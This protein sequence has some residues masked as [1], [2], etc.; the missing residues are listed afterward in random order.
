MVAATYG[1]VSAVGQNIALIPTL[2]TGM[3]WFPRTKGLAMGCVVGGF[4]GGSL[5][6]NYIITAIINPENISPAAS[7]PDEG[8]FTEPGLLARVPGLLLTLSGIYLGLGLLACLLIT[9]PPEDWLSQFKDETTSNLDNEYVTPLEAFK[10]KEFYL[11]WI[12]RLSVVMLSNVIS[13]FYK[14]FGQTF[15]KDDKFLSVVGSISSVFNCS[16]RLLWGLVMDRFSY[17]VSMSIESAILVILTST[18]YLTSMIGVSNV[19]DLGCHEHMTNN[20]TK[21]SPS[22]RPAQ[23]C[24]SE[25]PTTL[26]TKAVYA[27]WVW[28]IFLTFPGTFSM[29]PAVTTQIFGHRYGGSIYA[30]LFSSD[31][32]NNLLVATLSTPIKEAYGWLGLFLAIS[33]S[34]VVAFIA[35]ICF[36][37]QAS[38]KTTAREK[39]IQ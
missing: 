10:R 8:Y 14:V 34:G 32:I 21:I 35:S 30:F 18:F 2:T 27:A 26:T 37:N 6:F 13:A 17:K 28:S 5:A 11:L 9:Q 12:T 36:S 33:V 15:I 39:M 16:G 22:M 4:G 20:L 24:A 25:L 1:F 7:G 38:S 19:H 23:L 3:K 31:L 29:Q